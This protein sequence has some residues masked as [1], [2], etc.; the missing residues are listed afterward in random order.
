MPNSIIKKIL[1]QIPRKNYKI[2]LSLLALIMLILLFLGWFS[3]RLIN[4][5]KQK[6]ITD[7]ELNLAT[8]ERNLFDN[9]EYSHSIIDTINTNIQEDPHNKRHIFNIL[10]I[11]RDNYKFNQTLSWTTFS[12]TDDKSQLTV[13]SQYGILKE[14]IDC[15]SRQHTSASE[16]QAGRLQIGTPVIGETSKK[17]IIPLSVGV[18]DNGKNYVGATS[19]GLEIEALTRILHN[20]I[21]NHEISF[22][23]IGKNGAVMIDTGF[24]DLKTNSK[25]DDNV[26]NEDLTKNLYLLNS[27]N[28]VQIKEVSVI[29]NPH[30]FLIKKSENYPYIFVLEYDKNSIRKELFSAMLGRI[31]EA[32]SIIFSFLFL[33]FLIYREIKQKQKS[34]RFKMIA[35]RANQS[36]L[37]FLVKSAHEFK[38]FIFGIQ[39]CAEV[40]R[41]DLKKLQQAIEKNEVHKKLLQNHNI[42]TDIEFARDIIEVSH[43]LDNFI[44]Q[45]VDVDYEKEHDLQINPSATPI[46]VAQIIKNC[47][48][49]LE[50][51]AHNAEI[52]LVSDIEEKLHRISKIDDKIL[53]QFLT[54][55][56]SNAIKHS[57]N[58][59]LV[60][61]EAK[62]I[63]D[64]ETLKNIYKIH[65]I[66]K[67]EA[68]EIVI[69]NQGFGINQKEIKTA[70][71][72]KEND[73]NRAEIFATRLSLIK[74]LIE[75]QGGIF[76]VK[77]D[78]NLNNEFRI[79]L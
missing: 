19:I 30:A 22:K 56:I 65:G 58:S 7:M 69:K 74:Y 79:I 52:N 55:L 23:L 29:K 3:Y 15:S 32:A 44:N 21:K 9:I 2:P 18:E 5:A 8:I 77:S 57:R 45:L 59:G 40:I 70:L 10:K 53:K 11:Y 50:K 39:G 61:V 33:L 13:D 36:K 78:T 34:L 51:R 63:D 27:K 42:K 37:E 16:T 4:S 76:E 48:K 46:D 75:K 43:D 60:A 28:L 54:I 73:P 6:I 67:E 72:N 47:V 25:H 68:V 31:S 14:P 24:K 66:K 64:K 49:S 12:W 20:L 41:D 1:E 17:L 71:P 35:Q 38:N 26:D 62:N